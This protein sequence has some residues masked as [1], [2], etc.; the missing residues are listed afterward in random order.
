[1]LI[2]IDDSGDPG[3]KLK[4]GSSAVFVIVMVIFKDNL[5]AEETALC[6]KKLKRE[7]GFRDEY[8]FKFNKC[9]RDLRM[10]FLQSIRKY[11]FD[12]RAIVVIKEKIFSP[13]LRGSKDKFYNF[14]IRNL[15]S[16]Y[17]DKFFDK[18][19]VKIDGR[20]SKILRKDFDHYLR[21][22]V[23]SPGKNRIGRIKHVNSKSDMLIQFA[24]MAAGSIHR[25]YNVQKVDHADYLAIIKNRTL[26]WEFK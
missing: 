7:L 19:T 14:I 20:A 6:I 25:S 26:I 21:K 4:K 24:D 5:V 8:E 15:L 11:N 16:H 23:N 9:S 17:E 10:K 1:M 12:I 18:A 3:F 13:T 22:M 2:F